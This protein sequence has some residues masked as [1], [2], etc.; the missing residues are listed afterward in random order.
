MVKK[1]TDENLNS[2]GHFN[3]LWADGNSWKPYDEVRLDALVRTVKKRDKV[4][5]LGGG[6]RGPGEWLIRQKRGADVTWIDFSR[7]AR[8]LLIEKGVKMNYLLADVTDIP[9]RGNLF[10]VVIAGELI[11]HMEHPSDLVR[12]MA[13]LSKPGGSLTISTV[14][15]SSEA[16]IEHGVYPEH[17]FEFEADDLIGFFEPFGKTVYETVGNYHFIEC[18]LPDWKDVLAD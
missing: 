2:P 5:D 3:R 18:R 8:D 11:E 15:T 9:L 16:A 6:L 1:L 7:T 12:E 17:L 14:D 13:R 10:D 4:A